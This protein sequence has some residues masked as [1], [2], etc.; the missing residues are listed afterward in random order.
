MTDTA[1]SKIK[2]SNNTDNTKI[3]NII[4]I[5]LIGPLINTINKCPAT[6]LAASRMESVPEQITF[7]TALITTIINIKATGVLLED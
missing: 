2:S 6:M 3:I 7:L 5:L 4:L 1:N